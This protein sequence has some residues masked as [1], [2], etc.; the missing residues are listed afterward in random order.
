MT[1]TNANNIILTKDG[2]QVTIATTADE[3]IWTKTLSLVPAPTVTLERDINTGAKPIKIVDLLLKAERRIT[4]NGFI[5]FDDA[6][7]DTSDSAEDKKVDL[8]KI[9]F[10]GGTITLNYEGSDL[11]INIEKFSVKR[12]LTDGNAAAAGEVEFSV[13]FTCIVGE[14]YP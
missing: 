1:A 11:V 9:F 3:E 5:D 2:V 13:L 8:R 14:D 12:I 10:A 4:F 6:A 7:G